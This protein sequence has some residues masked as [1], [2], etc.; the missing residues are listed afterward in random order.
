MAIPNALNVHGIL[1][2]DHENRWYEVDASRRAA[3]YFDKKYGKGNK[4]YDSNKPENFFDIDSF[5]LGRFSQ[6]TNPRRGDY[7]Q[8]KGNPVSGGKVSIWEIL[9]SLLTI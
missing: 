5:I 2:G 3:H 6:Y 4:N 9:F 1:P 7:Y 8:G